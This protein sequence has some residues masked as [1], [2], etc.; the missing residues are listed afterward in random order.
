MTSFY[1]VTLYDIKYNDVFFPTAL[2]IFISVF[3]TAENAAV[4]LQS[5]TNVLIEEKN[6]YEMF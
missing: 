3:N 5:N 6:H 2:P 1:I 4:F